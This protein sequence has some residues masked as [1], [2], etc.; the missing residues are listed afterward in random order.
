[1]ASLP[2]ESILAMRYMSAVAVSVFVYDHL[3]TWAEE[4]RLIWFNSNA[5]LS[6]RINYMV[7]RYSTGAM[8]IYVAY[9]DCPMCLRST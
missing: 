6:H 9:S 1:M 4:I 2:A 7:N 8:L 3:L 5:D